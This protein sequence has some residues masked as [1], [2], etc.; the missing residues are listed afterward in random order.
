M[1]QLASHMNAPIVTTDRIVLKNLLT[2]AAKA[3]RR[4][5]PEFLTTTNRGKFANVKPSSEM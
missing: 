3:C 5:V 2:L 4:Q 1:C